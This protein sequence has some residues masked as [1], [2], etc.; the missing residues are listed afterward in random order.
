MT[1][2]NG[3]SA[4]K[5]FSLDMRPAVQAEMQAILQAEQHPP[6]DHLHGMMQY[7]M[8]W[9]DEQFEQTTANAG[10]QMRPLFV[11][12]ACQAAG[13]SWRDAVPVAAGVE[14]LHNFSLIHDDIEDDSPTR[15]GRRTLWNIW[16][17]PLAINAGDAMFALAHSAFTRLTDHGVPAE[18]IVRA[19][20]RFD[21]TNL[22]LTQGQHA[23]MQ[24][25]QR[26][27]VTTA[28]YIDMITGKTSVLSGLCT[29]LGALIAGQPDE[30]VGH[31][32]QFGL[33]LGLAF[34]VIDDILGIWGDETLIGKSVSTDIETRKKTLPVLFGLQESVEM[35][36]LYAKKR[37]AP[38][39]VPRVIE[40]LNDVKAR[41]YAEAQAAHYT[42]LALHHLEQAQPAGDAAVAMQELTA[43]LLKRQA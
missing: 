16:G 12:L 18:T 33:N 42:Q 2:P 7:H 31:Y 20:K 27:E 23:D 36:A 4:L 21:E 15:R 10:K 5:V 32:A 9:L 8:G 34:Q 1:Y 24:F 38:N 41:D 3:N 37:T 22:R 29:E 13:G 17:I 39:F 40:L 11:L 19:L 28:E 14:L 30:I 25:E 43:M 35:R 26:D 6:I